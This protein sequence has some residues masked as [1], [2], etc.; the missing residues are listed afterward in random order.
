MALNQTSLFGVPSLDIRTIT[1]GAMVA[2]EAPALATPAGFSID[3][4]RIIGYKRT[5]LGGTPG[6]PYLA[7][8]SVASGGNPATGTINLYFRSTNALDTSVYTVY[9]YNEDASPQIKSALS[10]L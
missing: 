2:G 6:T 8:V 10:L 7:V 3:K 1:L 9:F 5:T 4:S